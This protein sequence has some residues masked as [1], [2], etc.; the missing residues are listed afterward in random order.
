MCE[1]KYDEQFSVVL[2]A[3]HKLMKHFEKKNKIIG[4]NRAD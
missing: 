2:E 1:K 4:F 3:I